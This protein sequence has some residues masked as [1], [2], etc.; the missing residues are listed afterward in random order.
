VDL[1]VAYNI[2]ETEPNPNQKA[3]EDVKEIQ[4]DDYVSPYLSLNG[5]VKNSDNH[6]VVVTIK[7]EEPVEEE[8]PVEEKENKIIIPNGKVA[9][10]YTV[11]AGESLLKIADLFN[12]RVSEIRNWNNIPYTKNISVGQ[13]LQVYVPENREEYYASL[14]QLSS[15]EKQSMLTKS[16]TVTKEK[17]EE[18]VYHRI[19]KG[20][21]LGRIAAKYG[22]SISSIKRWNNLKSNKILYGQ[23]LKISTGKKYTYNSNNSGNT[24]SNAKK[25]RYKIKKGDSI[26]EIAEMF[27]VRA[28]QIRKW[29]GMRGSKIIAGKYLTIYTNED[30]MPTYGDNTNKTS[31]TLNYYR[32]QKGDALIRIAKQF[33]VTVSQ[34]REWNN[35]S[36]NKIKIG[37]KLKIYSN[38]SPHD[39]K[40][41]Y[42]VI[43]RGESL[44]T[45]AKKYKTSVKKLKIL[46]K[47]TSNKIKI[48]KKLRVR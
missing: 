23:T 30:P 15:T 11:K 36:G 28:S 24:T 14:N 16:P 21:S 39:V 29:N 42:H 44:W 8:K 32:V 43:Q 13:N 33:G 25:F 19:R 45:I 18:W 9:V 48:G 38:S 6:D 20:E 1:N 46:N 37:Q 2:N 27:G 10:E 22:V 47:L 26:G 34:I 7:K 40:A 12:V 35:L 4:P 17:K 41:K 5:R 31:A 3:P